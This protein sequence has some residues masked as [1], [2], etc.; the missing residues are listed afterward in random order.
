M[1]RQAT[2]Q[3]RDRMCQIYFPI[4]G[5]KLELPNMLKSEHLPVVVCFAIRRETGATDAFF[6]RLCSSR[7]GTSM[8]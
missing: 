2:W 3:E 8:Y 7:E 6:S 4:E 1:L 5:R